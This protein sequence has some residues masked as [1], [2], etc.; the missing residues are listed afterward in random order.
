[1]L[2]RVPLSFSVEEVKALVAVA[3]IQSVDTALRDREHIRIGLGFF[4]VGVGEVAQQREIDVFV[5][6]CEIVDLESLDEF[7]HLRIV[8][9]DG[10]HDDE[11]RRV[12]WNA[13]R[14]VHPR[15]QTWR[16]EVREIP[17]EHRDREIACRDQRQQRSHYQKRP[18]DSESRHE[19]KQR[20]HDQERHDGEGTQI[21]CSAVSQQETTKS[22]D[23]PWLI[24]KLRLECV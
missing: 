9:K 18:V 22:L 6:V 7:V 24:T 20:R 19:V 14:R 15:Q 8:Q 4:R 1:M 12:V 11:C 16:K 10:W 2:A 3:A 13:V 21:R 23:S 17:V 5:L